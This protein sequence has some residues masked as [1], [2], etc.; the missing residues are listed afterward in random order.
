MKVSVSILK[1]CNRLDYAIKK[2]N[3]SSADFLHVDVMDGKFVKNKAFLFEDYKKV[4]TEIKEFW[5]N[6]M[7][8]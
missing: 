4:V 3:E 1:E 7:F 2:V 5:K 6:S 8:I